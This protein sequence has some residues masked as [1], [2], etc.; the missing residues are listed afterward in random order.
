M[1]NYTEFKKWLE[2]HIEM[3]PS[4]I[5]AINFNLYEGADDSYH[6][7]VNGTESFDP[8]DEDW[9]CDDAFTTGE[10]I[11]EVPRTDDIQEWQEGLEYMTNMVKKYLDEGSF[12]SKLMNYEAVGI[13]FVD[14]DI[15]ILHMKK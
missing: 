9:A 7:Q 8:D 15:E 6:I 2:H 5:V 11:F 13:G 14:G 10:D 4:N 3:I 12:A 1:K